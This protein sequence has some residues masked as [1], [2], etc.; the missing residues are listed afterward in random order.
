MHDQ[1]KAASNAAEDQRHERVVLVHALEAQPTTL[2]LSDLLREL[3]DSE[4]FA[5]RDRIE[6]AVRELVKGGLLFRREGAVL[7]TRQALYA[8]EVW[9]K[10]S[11]PE[12]ARACRRAS[13]KREVGVEADALKATNSKTPSELHLVWS[14]PWTR[15]RRGGLLL[16]FAR[17]DYGWNRTEKGSKKPLLAR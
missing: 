14:A 15:Q 9:G 11:K 17:S 10:L 13:S 6:R 4:D 12:H 2:R 1:P 3:G 5:A 7:L 16:R 8:Y